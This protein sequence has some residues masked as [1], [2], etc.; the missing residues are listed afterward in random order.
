MPNCITLLE[1][2][3]TFCKINTYSHHDSHP[4]Y[5]LQSSKVE[6]NWDHKAQE[7][8]W[9]TI[10]YHN[11]CIQDNWSV[12]MM[13]SNHFPKNFGNKKVQQWCGCLPGNDSETYA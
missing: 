11:M 7:G 3:C 6:K 10:N 5:L 8:C 13:R 9:S 4:N 2:R 1:P 12:C